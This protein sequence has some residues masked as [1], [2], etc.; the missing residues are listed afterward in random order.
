M[1]VLRTIEEAAAWVAEKDAQSAITIGNYDGI[2]RGHLELIH[3]LESEAA[4]KQLLSILITFEPHPQA[5]LAKSNPP[6][7]LTTLNEKLRVLR[8]QTELD[9]VLILEFNRELAEVSAADFLQEFLVKRLACRSIVIGFNHAFGHKRE[10]NLEFLKQHAA[11]LGYDLVAVEP[12]L[13]G[14][15]TVNSSLVRE[16]LQA[17]RVEEAIALLGHDLEFTGTVIHGKGIGREQGYPTINVKL[18]D[19]KIVLPSGVYAAYTIVYT[20]S[21][22]VSGGESGGG[23]GEGHAERYYGMMYVGETKQEFDLEVNLFDFAGDLYDR[24]V[25]VYPVAYTRPSIRFASTEELIE[26][27]GRDEREIKSKFNLI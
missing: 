25:S 1:Q 4:R 10:G 24:R 26:Q 3:R 9:A 17:G 2:H 19:E 23:S 14:D 20:K 12:V 15:K 7:I 22:S 16:L 18:P 6:A 21:V 11:A 8:E 27:I 5:V 13:N